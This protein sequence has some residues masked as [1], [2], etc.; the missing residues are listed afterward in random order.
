MLLT[1]SGIIRDRPSKS[2]AQPESPAQRPAACTRTPDRYWEAGHRTAGITEGRP[3]REGNGVWPP[4]CGQARAHGRTAVS[5]R[6]GV[7][8]IRWRASLDPAR[9]RTRHALFAAFRGAGAGR[10]GAG[11]GSRQ[12]PGSQPR[13]LTKTVLETALGCP[14]NDPVTLGAPRASTLAI[15]RASRIRRSNH[16]CCPTMGRRANVMLALRGKADQGRR[17]GPSKS[18]GQSKRSESSCT[19]ATSLEAGHARGGSGRGPGAERPRLST[20]LRHRDESAGMKQPVRGRTEG[21]ADVSWK[22]CRCSSWRKTV[23]SANAATS[24]PASSPM[25]IVCLVCL[26]AVF[27]AACTR[28]KWP[29][30]AS[31]LRCC[32]Q[33]RSAD[34][35]L[36]A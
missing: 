14:P 34:Y 13:Q 30:R 10:L 32:G 24:T 19:T 25:Q 16:M 12:R 27:P 28:V 23:S 22:W 29:S 2:A 11:G 4:G 5:I 36:R 33:S 18:P 17:T 7:V 20:V 15:S 21:G 3:R 6:S 31:V 9:P 35:K 26:S 8:G 1:R